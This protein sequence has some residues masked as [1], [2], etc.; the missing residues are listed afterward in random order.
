MEYYS[1][2]PTGGEEGRRRYSL[3]TTSAEAMR[4]IEQK[5]GVFSVKPTTLFS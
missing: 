1:S 4:V 5:A 2:P 3:D